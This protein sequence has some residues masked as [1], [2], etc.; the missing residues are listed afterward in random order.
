M[1]TQSRRAVRAGARREIAFACRAHR[2]PCTRSMTAMG[3]CCNGSGMAPACRCRTAHGRHMVCHRNARTPRRRASTS[4]TPNRMTCCRLTAASMPKACSR[5]CRTVCCTGVLPSARGTRNRQTPV[6]SSHRAHGAAYQSRTS[7]STL[8]M[9]TTR[10]LDSAR[11][12][13]RRHMLRPARDP[14]QPGRAAHRK[15]RC[16]QPSAPCAWFQ[17]RM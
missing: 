5:C 3:S 1:G 9:Q 4:L 7:A 16:L 10:P 15:Q 11:R 6:A 17:L 8:P 13:V 12:T 14:H 2:S